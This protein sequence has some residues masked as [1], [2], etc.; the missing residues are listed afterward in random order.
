MADPTNR[1]KILPENISN[2]IAIMPDE[3]LYNLEGLILNIS[4]GG[5][6]IET[7]EKFSEDDFLLMRFTVQDVETVENVLGRVKRIDNCDKY[8]LAGIEFVQQEELNDR[9]SMPELEILKDR[10]SNFNNRI[11]D[12]LEK[13][14]YKE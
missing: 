8:C 1:I 9:L 13:F 5:V 6:L 11:Q 14:M 3:E 7:E 2:K 12:T 10:I 4:M